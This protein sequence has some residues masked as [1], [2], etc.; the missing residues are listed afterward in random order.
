MSRGCMASAGIRGLGAGG[1][2]APLCCYVVNLCP[3]A[4]STDTQGGS[5]LVTIGNCESSDSS[6]PPLTAP[7]WAEERCLISAGREEKAS[8]VVSTDITRVGW[9]SPPSAVDKSPGSPFG[10]H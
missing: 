4:I 7:H 10:L 3:C 9:A 8:H 1:R 6:R 2:A 5:G